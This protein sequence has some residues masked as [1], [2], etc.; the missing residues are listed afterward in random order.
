MT[1]LF[2]SCVSAEGYGENLTLDGIA[3]SPR[4]IWVY[5]KEEQGKCEEKGL[6]LVIEADFKCYL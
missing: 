3:D 1:L 6:V 5:R 4:N 2:T